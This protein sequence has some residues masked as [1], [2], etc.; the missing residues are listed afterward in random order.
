MINYQIQNTSWK[1]LNENKILDRMF[2][3]AT[4]AKFVFS[5]L[6]NSMIKT[7]RQPNALFT[8]EYNDIANDVWLTTQQVK[9]A[10]VRLKKEKILWIVFDAPFDC[11]FTFGFLSLNL[12]W[13]KHRRRKRYIDQNKQLM[14]YLRNSRIAEEL[15]W[16]REE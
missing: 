5:A 4:N 12:F 15:M 16:K 3:L 2:L 9:A 7:G 6:K 14:H 10:L 13:F 8:V 1:F 11:N